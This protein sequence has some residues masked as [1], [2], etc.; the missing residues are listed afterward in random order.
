MKASAT[1]ADTGKGSTSA[2][3]DARHDIRSRTSPMNETGPLMDQIQGL[4]W[5]GEGPYTE[6]LAEML[7]SMPLVRRQKAVRSL[8][9]ARG[10][11]FV[12]RL[13]I[14]AKLN[15][16]P[17]GDRYEREA[18]HVAD[19]V[20][21]MTEPANPIRRQNKTVAKPAA[22]SI[23]P[24]IQR[25]TSF[26]SPFVQRQA[27]EEE[28]IQTKGN[29]DKFGIQRKS[30]DESV[31]QFEEKL[32]TKTSPGIYKDIINLGQFYV[33]NTLLTKVVSQ[34]DSQVSGLPVG[35]ARNR[36]IITLRDLVAS[37]ESR[38]VEAFRRNRLKVLRDLKLF[39]DNTILRNIEGL[40]GKDLR[41]DREKLRAIGTPLYVEAWK[42]IRLGAEPDLTLC[43]KTRLGPSLSCVLA[44]NV[45]EAIL[46]GSTATRV[47]NLVEGGGIASKSTNLNLN[48]WDPR[49]MNNQIAKLKRELDKGG[50]VQARVL[51]P[52][53]GL[54]WERKIKKEKEKPKTKHSI[55][56]VGHDGNKK[57]VFWD[58]D[59]TTT[60]SDLTKYGRGYGYLKYQENERIFWAPTHPYQ[61]RVVWTQ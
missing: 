9:R 15:V 44:V 47:E 56:I 42:K 34:I 39:T 1:K 27:E 32:K 59:A 43:D 2:G 48:F 45:A 14:Q 10:N 53:K 50:I 60:E 19:Q 57:F 37:V 4:N 41:V 40:I 36:I 35:D 31:N 54:N 24:L 28:D 13:A 12:Q 23:T 11:I 55:L 22:S 16:G 5:G 26:I 61:Y 17:I 33:T 38:N 20:I 46:C 29:D 3:K 58:P 8:Q 30:I 51:S 18:D 21:S 6:G 7:A 49:D 25:L 52:Y